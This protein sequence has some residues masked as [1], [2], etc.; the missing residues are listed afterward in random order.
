MLFGWVYVI[1]MIF[2]GA[3][4]MASEPV[5]IVSVACGPTGAADSEL[6]T[7]ICAAFLARLETVVTAD[8]RI[9]TG[10]MPGDK[11]DGT[12]ALVWTQTGESGVKGH[13]E[14]SGLGLPDQTGPVVEAAV[15]DGPSPQ[16]LADQFIHGLFKL[17]QFA[18]D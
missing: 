16:A 18:F 1:V 2:A 9:E 14:M 8:I 5:R 13:I 10:D 7:K 11:A 6:E 4:V 17:T 12:I 15:L 3:N